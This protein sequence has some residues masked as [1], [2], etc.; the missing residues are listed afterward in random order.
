[1]TRERYHRIMHEVEQ[2]LL[3]MGEMVIAVIDRSIQ[4]LKNGDKAEAERIIADDALINQRRWDIENQCL[5]L[6]ATQQP[7]AGDL[8]EIV[9]FIDLITNLERM[10]DHAKGIAII[11]VRHDH[12]PLLK[13]LI[14][15]P[16]MA[17][18]AREMIQK[19][20]TA[21]ITQDVEAA[22]AII[23]MDNEVDALYDQ[24]FRELLTYMMEDPKTITRAVYLIW[25]SHNL[26]RI[27]DRVTNI[28]E[29]IIFMVTGEIQ[30]D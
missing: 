22:A 20:L 6:F 24:I 12:K 3:Q 23:K 10:A 27:A 1:M 9:S 11:V 28:C 21:F 25:V 26:E 2:E 14:D 5:Q 30:S 15:I 8:R 17:D 18:K 29:R 13:P 7:V 16:R 4:A 19:S